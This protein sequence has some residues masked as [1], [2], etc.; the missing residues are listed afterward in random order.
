MSR[1]R[2]SWPAY[3]AAAWAAA[4]AVRGVYWAMG[5]TVGLG[6]LS[7]DLQARA[8]ADDSAVLG[9][10]WM[11]VALLLLGSIW[12]IALARTWQPAVPSRTL[13]DVGRRVPAWMVFAP[14]AAAGAVLVI[15]GSGYIS[16]LFIADR[17]DAATWWYGLVWG[18]WFVLGGVLF[19]FAAV[20]YRQQVA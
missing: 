4:F 12:A 3:A 6:T 16:G 7:E 20:N 9:M 1:K 11:A 5:G 14:P 17:T 2:R 19:L 8:A 13:R 10:L 18:P 15:H